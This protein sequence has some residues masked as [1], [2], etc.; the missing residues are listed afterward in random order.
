MEKAQDRIE[1]NVLNIESKESAEGVF[2]DRLSDVL[3]ELIKLSEK[4]LTRFPKLPVRIYD[5][6]PY[7]LFRDKPEARERS[8]RFQEA[9]K[10]MTEYDRDTKTLIDE[11]TKINNEYNKSEGDC[12]FLVLSADKIRSLSV[13]AAD[14][15]R[16]W[17]ERKIGGVV[18]CETSAL[19]PMFSV[20]NA[21]RERYKDP[22][23]F[24]RFTIN[25][26]FA[27]FQNIP[28][29]ISDR[30]MRIYKERNSRLSELP[31]D[32]NIVVYDHQST[33][34]SGEEPITRKSFIPN[35]EGH[36]ERHTNGKPEY[37]FLTN[38]LLGGKQYIDS[39]KLKEKYDL[40]SLPPREDEPE[41][42]ELHT[43]ECAVVNVLK[44]GHSNIIVEFSSPFDV[45]HTFPKITH[46]GMA[47]IIHDDKTEKA[48]NVL[49]DFVLGGKLAAR[50]LE[51]LDL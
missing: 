31:E 25:Q 1:N 5:V 28:N 22:V 32:T 36:V 33:I 23:Y 38:R 51:K 26:L 19:Y 2:L 15:A 24:S 40:E 30:E 12:G 3:I 13:W 27:T 7:E 37:I 14:V 48:K 35:I 10:A 42:P 11:I 50:I 18:I 46:K 39:Q 4:M 49:A 44:T 9:L 29:H 34:R 6:D 20:K 21:M 16:D 43:A 45:Y 41:V 17:H 47:G 8:E